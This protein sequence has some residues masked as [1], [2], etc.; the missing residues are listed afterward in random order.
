MKS[1]IEFTEDMKHAIESCVLCW[2]ATVDEQ[3]GANASPKE[4][5]L[6]CDNTLLIANIASP[7][8]VKNIR[9]NPHVCVSFVHTFRQK[10]YKIKGL[11][12]EHEPHSE[13]YECKLALLHERWGDRF[14]VLSIIEVVPEKIEEI[15]APSYYLFEGVTEE[16]MVDQAL[17]TYGVSERD[18]ERRTS[19]D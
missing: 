18:V 14:P 6:A 8:S 9:S 15:I 13:S 17:D 11:A 19:D 5:F 12:I 10:G 7:V 16:Q 1:K 4:M 3:G 2:L